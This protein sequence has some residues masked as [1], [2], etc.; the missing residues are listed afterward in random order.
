MIA[1]KG[2]YQWGIIVSILILAGWSTI[3][4]QD[5]MDNIPGDAFGNEEQ[6]AKGEDAFGNKEAPAKGEDAFGN[7]ETPSP[8]KKRSA[9]EFD[10][11]SEILE[12][13]AET[14]SEDGEE[15]GLV[16]EAA[17]TTKEVE[18]KKPYR[19]S[20]K[21]ITLKLEE[22]FYVKNNN[23]LLTPKNLVHHTDFLHRSIAAV[24]LKIDYEDFLSAIVKDTL[25][26][27]IDEDR[28]DDWNN[29]FQEGYTAIMFSDRIY[30]HV[31]K[32]NYVGGISYAWNPTDYF[33]QNSDIF[34]P[35]QD[36]Q[37]RREQRPGT[38]LTKIE[39]FSPIG[40]AFFIYAPH[41][42][43][44]KKGFE[45][46]QE[47]QYYGKIALA[48]FQDYN[49]EISFYYKD[50]P[51]FGI[52]WSGGVTDALVVQ[53]EAAVTKG[54]DFEI[55]KEGPPIGSPFDPQKTFFFD[56][57]PNRFYLQAVVG[58]NYTLPYNVNLIAEYYYNQVGMSH[59]ELEK[60][61]DF[62]EYSGTRADNPL[63]NDP[64]G[65]NLY[66]GY[67]G[68]AAERFNAARMG[69]HYFFI[70]VARNGFISDDLNVSLNN[71][72]NLQDPSVA[73]NLKFDYALG[74]HFTFTT[75]LY[76]FMGSRRSEFGWVP[77]SFRA[78]LEFTALF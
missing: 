4:A 33:A 44:G 67:I 19:I 5:I 52:N 75:A 70:R 11:Y 8:K 61:N 45:G 30:L 50:R 77:D 46:N 65:R 66:F 2:L 14:E 71:I 72:I 39:Y 24:D 16:E 41:I 35:E 27:S 32:E 63:F 31:G 59:R 40:P 47:H 10:E 76:G 68:S 9:L 42:D 48:I 56:K 22:S 21:K 49:P 7:K 29:Y 1:G 15:Y 51:S 6:S 28:N 18:V 36:N 74:E 38:Y 12:E 13:P 26:W 17:K 57:R 58:I 62:L 43:A 20:G 53:V 64:L 69:Q 55:I 34:G 54:P 3:S 78:V 23:S 37:S 60:H 73:S 25:I